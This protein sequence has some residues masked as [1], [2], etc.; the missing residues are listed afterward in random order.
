MSITDEYRRHA[1][2]CLRMATRMRKP[3]ERAA[4]L[5]L[6]QMWLRRLSALAR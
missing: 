4:W 2:E 1:D 3:E 6:A 5:A